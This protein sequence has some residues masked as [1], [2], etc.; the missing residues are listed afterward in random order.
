VEYGSP[1]PNPFV[2]PGAYPNPKATVAP[3]L[4]LLRYVDYDHD[5]VV[6]SVGGLVSLD[7]RNYLVPGGLYV[8]YLAELDTPGNGQLLYTA[9]DVE[10][11]VLGP[12]GTPVAEGE[13]VA[14][15]LIAEEITVGKPFAVL[16]HSAFRAFS[17]TYVTPANKGVGLGAGLVAT[18]RFHNYVRQTKLGLGTNE[19]LELPVVARYSPNLDGVVVFEAPEG[20]TGSVEVTVN[21][22]NNYTP[23]T[24]ST[25]TNLYLGQVV[26]LDSR[27]PKGYLQYVQTLYNVPVDNP[28]TPF[29]LNAGDAMPG[30]ATDGLPQEIHVAGGSAALGTVRVRLQGF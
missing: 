5:F 1:P 7:S 23:V 20:V 30:S 14:A 27:Y 2:Y 10:Y 18:S 15:K 17:D 11:G 29:D 9:D 6:I 28:D 24:E 16:M 19:T 25:P 21:Y 8:D 12:D 22:R 26:D 4:P 13:S 3:Y